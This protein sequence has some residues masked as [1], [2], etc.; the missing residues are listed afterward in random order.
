MTTPRVQ[1]VATAP[2]AG[3]PSAFA[4]LRLANFR[5]LLL[6]TTLSNSAQWIQQVTLSWLVYDLT[7]SGTMLG[8]LNLVRSVATLGLA[9]AAG[10]AIDRLAR[11][12]LM[13]VTNGWLCAISLA[14]GLALLASHAAIWPLFVF[15]FLGGVAQAIDLP[16]RQT[17]VF[18]LV[19]R[20]LVTG[21]VA[22]VQ[23]GWA[24]M[25]SLGPALGGFLIL[26]VG[27]GGNFLVQAAVYALITLTIIRIRFPAERADRVEGAMPGGLRAGLRYVATERTTRAFLL[28][29]WVLP[30]CII[31]NFVALPPIYA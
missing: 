6:G 19:P 21:A 16:L 3:R 14:L 25:R 28:M 13:F 20:L 22:L 4:V 23:T 17:V 5:W 2:N 26:W 9:L 27:P 18:V 30:L 24:L 10:V 7:A 12:T 8:T 15:T 31:P 1:P 11:R 29:G